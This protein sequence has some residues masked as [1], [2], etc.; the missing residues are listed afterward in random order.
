MKLSRGQ[1]F[2]FLLLYVS[3]AL[4][5]VIKRNYSFWKDDLVKEGLSD[6][7]SIGMLGALYETF[8]GISKVA[9]AVLVD[10]YS[11]T[12][13]L[14]LSLA[15]QGASC[16]FFL[17]PFSV[18]PKGHSVSMQLAR[19]SWGMNGFLQAFS[20]P[21]LTQIFMAWFPLPQERG[22]WY[23][24]LGTCQ[25][26][27]AALA[28]LVTEY[29]ASLYGWRARIIF[30][31]LLALLYSGALYFLLQDRPG[32]KTGEALGGEKDAPLGS[33]LKKVAGEGRGSKNHPSILALL[34]SPA[35]PISNNSSSSA[36]ASAESPQKESTSGS[37]TSSASTTP[38][39]SAILSSV[40]ASRYMWLLALTY[41]FNSIVRNGIA[42]YVKTLLV[43]ELG[44]SETTAA[45][46]NSAYETGGAV[47]GL[48]C[49]ALSDALFDGRR[50]PV[51]ALFSFALIPLPLLLMSLRGAALSAILALYFSLGLT[52]FPA[53]VLNG[54]ASREL[55]LPY[56]QSTAGG[57][58]KFAG[59][60]G[61]SLVDL[62]ALGA[63]EL[64]GWGGV[65]RGLA[66]AAAVS[67][68][69]HLPLW[70]ARALDASGKAKTQ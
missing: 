53:H 28:P 33:P 70:N 50:G 2:T 18:F 27:G 17:L 42:T 34:S 59:Q 16:L 64:W 12:V 31:G 20:W 41:L 21:A 32:T 6:S 58:T 30:P 36:S 43:G 47:G 29:A 11:P 9:G 44:H 24:V 19:V 60:V 13:V 39:L 5:L 40:L 4:S 63:A 68:V 23:G 61:A 55:A 65:S 1:L 69:L 62:L 49:G 51:M 66:A 7:S 25:N 57:F 22:K 38:P 37:A 56:A 35:A 45:W 46:A 8:S 14:A 26:T 15:G 3:Y 48:L 67:A 10:L 52:A 54:L